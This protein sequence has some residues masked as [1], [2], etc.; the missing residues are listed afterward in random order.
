MAGVTGQK[1]SIRASDVRR[2][3]HDT[4]CCSAAQLRRR[5][6]G[7]RRRLLK[8]HA[9]AAMGLLCVEEGD[10]VSKLR[11]SASLQRVCNSNLPPRPQLAFRTVE[12]GV[13]REMR[14]PILDRADARSG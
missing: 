8:W 14:V 3:Q 4:G 11:N 6:S 9:F 5:H 1:G 10:R 13:N 7:A 2:C 12:G